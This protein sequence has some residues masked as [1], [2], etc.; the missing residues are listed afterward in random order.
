M[1]GFAAA[2]ARV[3]GSLEQGDIITYGEVAAEAGHP[4]AARAVGR[5]LRDLTDVPWWRVVTARGRVCPHAVDEAAR[6]LA[7][8]GVRVVGGHVVGRC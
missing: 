4:G 3:L 1:A 2:V 5:V 7:E 6:R 8:E